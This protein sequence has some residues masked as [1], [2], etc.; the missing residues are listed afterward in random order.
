M[1]CKNFTQPHRQGLRERT[2]PA[3]Q[4]EL[5]LYVHFILGHKVKG[6]QR[7]ERLRG[8]H[9]FED[10]KGLFTWREEDPRKRNNFSFAL[11]AEILAEVVAKWRRKRRI[12][13]GL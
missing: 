2:P 9:E 4:V 8:Y 6:A 7:K 1:N 10:Y 11:H 13:V 3:E 12:T 5:A